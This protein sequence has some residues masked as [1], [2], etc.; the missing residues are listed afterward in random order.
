MKKTIFLLFFIPLVMAGCLSQTSP[1]NKNE[2]TNT[3]NSDTSNKAGLANPASVYCE[4]QGGRLEIRS[5][6]DG[7]QNGIC[8]FVDDSE[9]EEWS[10]FR[11]ECQPKSESEDIS[12]KIKQLFVKKYQKDQAEVRVTVNQQTKNYARGG[13]KFGRDGI[14]EGGI[15]LASKVNG[16]WQLVFDGNGMISCSLIEDYDFPASMIPDC[17][18]Y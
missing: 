10:Y 15:F 11:G 5:S 18:E 16:E 2:E 14:G 6:S 7:S 13:V 3:N 8:V 12:D 1:S 4:Q 17:F 9:C